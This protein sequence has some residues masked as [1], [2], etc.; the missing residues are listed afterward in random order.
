[1]RIFPS[2]CASK[3]GA[4]ALQRNYGKYWSS[5][6]AA[7]KGTD[8][9]F[10]RCVRDCSGILCERFGTSDS[11]QRTSDSFQARGKHKRAKIQRKARRI[12]ERPKRRLR[13]NGNGQQIFK[14]LMTKVLYSKRLCI[15][16]RDKIFRANSR[17]FVDKKQR[18]SMWH[19]FPILWTKYVDLVIK[20]SCHSDNFVGVARLERATA[21]TPCK[22]ASRLHH[23]P[24]LS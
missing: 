20:K 14:R 19:P 15:S 21:C 24:K 3:T 16:L 11:G 8:L 6:S 2:P 22:N 4:I 18:M 5:G 10:T 7:V 1:M 12:A 9:F 13:T 17:L 23:T